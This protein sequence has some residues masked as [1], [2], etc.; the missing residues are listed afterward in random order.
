LQ[1][2]GLNVYI[3]IPNASKDPGHPNN[4]YLTPI[5]AGVVAVFA[6]LY[7]AAYSDNSLLQLN[8]AS[9]ERG[10]IFDLSHNWKS[11]HEQ[12]C[13]GTV[14][15]IR[16]NGVD[17]ALNITSDTDPMIYRVQK[18]GNKVGAIPVFEVPP[19]VAGVPVWDA[20]HFHTLLIGLEG[21][22]CP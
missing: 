14:V 9:L 17:G 10:G 6:N 22:Q 8:D 5:A 4:H 11:P 20:R 18:I 15:D 2:L 13:R 12:H 16:A 19:D 1:P 7:H 21:R 3:L